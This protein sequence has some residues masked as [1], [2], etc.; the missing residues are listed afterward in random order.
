MA[1]PSQA[2]FKGGGLFFYD[3]HKQEEASPPLLPGEAPPQA[4]AVPHAG[5]GPAADGCTAPRG[6]GGCGTSAPRGSGGSSSAC[7]AAGGPSLQPLGLYS[8]VVGTAVLHRGAQYHG[9]V[10]IEGGVRRNVV[11]WC[12]SRRH[13]HV[14]NRALAAAP[15]WAS[16]QA[17]VQAG[18][19]VA[20]AVAAWLRGDPDHATAA[21]VCSR[22]AD[23]RTLLHYCAVMTAADALGEVLAALPASELA[24]VDANAVDSVGMRPLHVAAALQDADTLR[25]LRRFPGVALDATTT[26]DVRTRLVDVATAGRSASEVAAAARAPPDVMAAL[27]P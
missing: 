15:A 4:V 26:V 25:A 24:L 5:A 16:V 23:G 21:H 19:S 9:A 11:L 10:A 22:D 13:P 7:A 2:G 1:L 14:L 20:A 27:E 12:R 3:L 18:E 6:G 17:A 8:H